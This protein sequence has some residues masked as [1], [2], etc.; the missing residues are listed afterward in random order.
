MAGSLC[1]GFDRLMGAPSTSRFT[2]T[3]WGTSTAACEVKESR[4]EYFQGSQ[5][6]N[7]KF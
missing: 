4:T 3:Y 2:P 7:S 1:G 6:G 5:S